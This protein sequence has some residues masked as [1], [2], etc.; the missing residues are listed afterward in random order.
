MSCSTTLASP[1][2]LIASGVLFYLIVRTI[3]AAWAFRSLMGLIR[4]DS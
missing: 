2:W 4:L 1:F 3:S